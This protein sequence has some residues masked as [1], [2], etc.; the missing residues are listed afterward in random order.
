MAPLCTRGR[1]SLGQS[2]S[3]GKTKCSANSSE[4]RSGAKGSQRAQGLCRKSDSGMQSGSPPRSQEFCSAT[5]S[6]LVPPAGMSALPLKAT[7]RGIP[8]NVH[9][10]PFRSCA[11]RI[12]WDARSKSPNCPRNSIGLHMYSRLGFLAPRWRSA[13]RAALRRCHHIP[14]WPARFKTTVRIPPP[15]EG[16]GLVIVRVSP[17]IA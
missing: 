9:F 17:E 1:S 12:R 7:F 10:V 8:V 15:P 6:A 14:F 3:T 5:S 13:R 2:R 11:V 4:C 16:V